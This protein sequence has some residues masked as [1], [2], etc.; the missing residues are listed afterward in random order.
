VAALTVAP[1]VW[2]PLTAR[3]PSTIV[4]WPLYL[5]GYVP[6]T[7]VPLY[8]TGSLHQVLPLEV[9]LVTSMAIL[10]LM[11][12]VRP[13]SIRLPHLSMSAFTWLLV[14][15]AI[16]SCLYI[17]AVFGI[18]A[19]PS[20]ANVYTTRAEFGAAQAGTAIGGYIVPWAANAIN[21]LLM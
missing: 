20:L 9:G 11:V 6:T 7:M 1:A 17:L 8:M 12:R 2:L 10:G 21:P 5:V 3:R 15:S 16:L 4:L 18:H 19:L 14:G 13:P